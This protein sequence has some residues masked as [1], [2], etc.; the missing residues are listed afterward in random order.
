M[1]T[2]VWVAIFVLLCITILVVSI[3]I[4][5]KKTDTKMKDIKKSVSYYEATDT[6]CLNCAY[7]YN[8]RNNHICVAK[9][10]SR[11]KECDENYLEKTKENELVETSPQIALEILTQYF[12]GSG[13][14]A[15]ADKVEKINTLALIDIMKAY[16]S[17]ENNDIMISKRRF[18]DNIVD[19]D[20]VH[21]STTLDFATENI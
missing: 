18:E 2:T 19:E 17:K 21:D 11:T 14:S 16:E 8:I 6:R 4:Q 15:R 13:Y 12:L 7:G 20:E 9:L 10:V 3:L 1:T 5:T